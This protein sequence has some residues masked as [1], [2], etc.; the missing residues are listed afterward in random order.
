MSR[1]GVI[2]NFYYGCDMINHHLRRPGQI[3]QKNLKPK[4][5]VEDEKYNAITELN[6][7][8]NL[9]WMREL[10]TF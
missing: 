1:L 9:Y 2:T 3:S 4:A 8:Y 7:S 6:L 10:C 5:D